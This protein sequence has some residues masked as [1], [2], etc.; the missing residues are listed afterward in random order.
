MKGQERRRGRLMAWRCGLGSIEEVD[1]V[2]V[3]TDES[4]C[5]TKKQKLDNNSSS[6]IKTTPTA[7]ELHN[8]FK[9][10]SDSPLKKM[11]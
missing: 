10:T 9:Q 8:Q 1:I 11:E 7:C 2:D 6:P 5:K 3:C 4:H